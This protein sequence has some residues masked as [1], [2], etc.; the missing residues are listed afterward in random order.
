MCPASGVMRQ[1]PPTIPNVQRL[2]ILVDNDPAGR[3]SAAYCATRWSRAG[4]RVLRLTPKVEGTD[5]ND[6]LVPEVAQ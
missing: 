4:R 1:L 5:F 2:I 6:L 3:E